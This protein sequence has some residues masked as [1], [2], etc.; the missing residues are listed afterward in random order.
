METIRVLRHPGDR[1]A[2]ITLNR[3]EAMNSISTELAGELTRACAEIATTPEIRAVV[4]SA[5]GDRAFCAGPGSTSKTPP[6]GRPHCRPTGGRESP[7][8]SRSARRFGRENP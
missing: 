5:A 1:V 3:P 2:E 6:G 4:L 8:S 7:P